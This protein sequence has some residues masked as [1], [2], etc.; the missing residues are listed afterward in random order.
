MT[1]VQSGGDGINIA[2]ACHKDP[3]CWAAYYEID[4]S[5][6]NQNQACNEQAQ[7][8]ALNAHI[9]P[10]MF[11]AEAPDNEKGEAPTEG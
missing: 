5:H 4:P 10:Q 7:L 11:C 1:R 9:F 2:S 8:N 3:V 6:N